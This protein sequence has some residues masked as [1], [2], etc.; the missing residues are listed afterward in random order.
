MGWQTE[1]VGDVNGDRYDDIVLGAESADGREPSAGRVDFYPG[2]EDELRR[3]FAEFCARSGRVVVCT[4]D[5][6]AR[7]ALHIAGV[8]AIGYGADPDAEVRLT[9]ETPGN[10]TAS[11]PFMRGY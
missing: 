3:A 10:R 9:I 8:D 5:E 6:G 1:S 7:A 4:D 11:R 2:G